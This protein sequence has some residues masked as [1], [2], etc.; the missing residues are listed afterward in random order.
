MYICL[1]NA[2]TDREVRAAVS[3][4]ARSLEDL[5]STLGVAT[6]CRR[7][8]GCAQAVLADALAGEAVAAPGDD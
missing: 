4:G 5:Q 1:C 2:I 8:T 7:C 3:L 6:C